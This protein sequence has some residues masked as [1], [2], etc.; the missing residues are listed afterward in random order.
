M[1]YIKC[2]IIGRSVHRS[3]EITVTYG[4]TRTKICG[5]AV[6]ADYVLCRLVFSVCSDS[7]SAGRHGFTRHIGKQSAS[8][9]FSDFS[10]HTARLLRL[11]FRPV[12]KNNIAYSGIS[13]NCY[14]RYSDKRT[15]SANYFQKKTESDNHPVLHGPSSLIATVIHRKNTVI[16]TTKPA[17]AINHDRLFS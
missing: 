10:V 1:G 8:C 9:V 11:D 7:H 5:C 4:H 16:T 14:C 2:K 13:F 6:T 3:S 17:E 12:F 15:D